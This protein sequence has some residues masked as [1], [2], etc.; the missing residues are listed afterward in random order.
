MKLM[1]CECLT[2]KRLVGVGVG[3]GCRG[4]GGINSNRI[5]CIYIYIL[6]H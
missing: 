1:G 4:E 3:R 6:T 2:E 5:T